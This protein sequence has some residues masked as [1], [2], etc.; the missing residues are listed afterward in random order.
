M[1]FGQFVNGTTMKYTT[2]LTTVC[3]N[4]RVNT[5]IL[6]LVKLKSFI[7]RGPKSHSAET[8][9]D[10]AIRPNK[11]YSNM[12]VLISVIN[13]NK[14]YV[15][16]F[17]AP[18]FPSHSEHSDVQLWYTCSSSRVLI[19]WSYREGWSSF[20]SQHN[21]SSFFVCQISCSNC[22]VDE[23]FKEVHINLLTLR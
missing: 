20:S 3:Y 7:G 11:I 23:I 22:K 16:F 18:S 9:A 1:L 14:W 8:N 2:V 5:P 13:E 10:L 19:R 21:F 4:K 17:F 6:T 15:N 12:F